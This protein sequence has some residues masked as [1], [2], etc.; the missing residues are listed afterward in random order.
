M[1]Q[2]WVLKKNKKI[3]PITSY[4][5]RIASKLSPFRA[6]EFSYSRGYIREILSNFLKIPALEIPLNAPPGNPPSLGNNLGNISL[7]HCKDAILLG[8]SKQKLGV[9]IERRDRI[10][11]AKN[12]SRIFFSE[13]EKKEL[14]LLEGDKM[15]LKSLKLWVLKE[16]AIKFQRG[17]LG[18]DISNWRIK[19]NFKNAF[20]K[21]LNLQIATDY[22][23]YK[24]W[25]LGVASEDDLNKVDLNLID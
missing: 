19:N 23:L 3:K 11:D 9:D 16:A 5:K 10:F 6:K 15:R 4:E 18:V 8:W 24:S 22:F 2:L 17:N 13:E 12:I 20:H 21:S 14:D 1:I 25:L 7:S